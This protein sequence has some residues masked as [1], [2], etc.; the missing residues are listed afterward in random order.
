MKDKLNFS[1]SISV[2]VDGN[3]HPYFLV[4]PNDVGKYLNYLST[5][6]GLES[7]ENDI[8]KILDVIEGREIST[9]ISDRGDCI[10][11]VMHSSTELIEFYEEFESVIISTSEF[12]RL[13]TDWFDFLDKYYGGKIPFIIPMNLRDEYKIVKR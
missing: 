10:F 8:K 12:L 11:K 6:Q 3:M 2:S 1:F 4:F 7:I 13:F 5:N 9:L